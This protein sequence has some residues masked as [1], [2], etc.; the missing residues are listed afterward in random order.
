MQQQILI[1]IPID[2]FE[3]RQ[4]ELIREV[5]AEQ[6]TPEPTSPESPDY[7]TRKETA[8]LLRISLP[9][10]HEW[11]KSG[12]LKS[13]RIAGKIRYKTAEIEAAFKQVDV[14]KYKR[15]V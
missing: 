4:K 11:T 8:K 9:T 13:Y 7:L 6:P 5:L 1:T 10:L 14:L 2:Q 15:K 12:D 3:T